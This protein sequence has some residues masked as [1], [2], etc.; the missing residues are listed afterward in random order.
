[1]RGQS[2]TIGEWRSDVGGHHRAVSGCQSRFRLKFT[3]HPLAARAYLELIYEDGDGIQLVILAL[4][5]HTVSMLAV[6][7]VGKERMAQWQAGSTGV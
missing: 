1:M 7:A 5:V 4:F 3:C 6:R 2:S